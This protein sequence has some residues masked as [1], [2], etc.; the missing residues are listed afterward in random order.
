MWIPENANVAQRSAMAP[1]ELMASFFPTT[2]TCRSCTCGTRA[3]RALQCRRREQFRVGILSPCRNEFIY[4]TH[5]GRKDR[6]YAQSHNAFHLFHSIGRAQ[7]ASS[8]GMFLFQFL[9]RF[10]TSEPRSTTSECLHHFTGEDNFTVNSH[11]LLLAVKANLFRFLIWFLSRRN[12]SFAWQ[13]WVFDFATVI[14][15]CFKIF[16][17]THGGQ[18]WPCSAHK[19]ASE[20]NKFLWLKMKTGLREAFISDSICHFLLE[21]SCIAFAWK[22]QIAVY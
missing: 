4:C 8:D 2:N 14:F 13:C 6:R 7:I 19:I 20:T 21:T 12:D 17:R 18:G 5:E 22:R 3:V 10:I 1:L 11:A 16:Y 9:F 15:Y